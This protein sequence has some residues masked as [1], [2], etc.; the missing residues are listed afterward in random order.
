MGQYCGGWWGGG[1]RNARCHQ[2]TSSNFFTNTGVRTH[3]TFANMPCTGVSLPWRASHMIVQHKQLSTFHI[4]QLVV[5]V[6]HSLSTCPLRECSLQE[7]LLMWRKRRRSHSIYAFHLSCLK[8][9][10]VQSC[11][12]MLHLSKCILII[13]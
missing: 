7:C 9:W 8:K 12:L 13:I 3:D 10:K 2:R 6:K 5:N 1:G 4:T 11:P